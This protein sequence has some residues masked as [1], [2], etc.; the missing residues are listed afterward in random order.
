MHALYLEGW[1]VAMASVAGRLLL[2]PSTLPGLLSSSSA[3]LASLPAAPRANLHR[4]M[5]MLAAKVAAKALHCSA[6]GT[7]AICANNMQSHVHL[8]SG[9][10]TACSGR[11]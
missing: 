3:M 4:T 7:E 8:L 5:Y 11:L 10:C 2:L 6:C 9:M 1:E